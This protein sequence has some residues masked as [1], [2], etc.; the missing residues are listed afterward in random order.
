MELAK[1]FR[2]MGHGDQV[3]PLFDEAVATI[4]SLRDSHA[5]L[6]ALT[7]ANG[8][9]LVVMQYPSFSLD[10]L[11]KYAPPADHV[12][13]VDNERVFATDPDACFHEPGFPHSFSHYTAH[14]ARLLAMNVA[15]HVL[16]LSS[17]TPGPQP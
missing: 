3:G 11:H 17:A 6:Y 5:R 12:S 1:L 9:H 10:H 8:T 13:F 2:Q 7:R 4:P 14:G 16:G 15:D